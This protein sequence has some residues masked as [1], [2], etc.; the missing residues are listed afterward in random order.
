MKLCQSKQV[1]RGLR[2]AREIERLKL[3][4]RGKDGMKVAPERFGAPLGDNFGEQQT[5]QTEDGSDSLG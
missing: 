3:L 1:H 4:K 2:K 5:I